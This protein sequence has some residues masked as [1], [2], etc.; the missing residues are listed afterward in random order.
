METQNSLFVLTKGAPGVLL[1]RCSR[2]LVGED[3][4]LLTASRRSEIL[5]SNEG[6]AGKA[7]RTLGVAFRQLPKAA[8]GFEV[9]DESVE[10]DLVFLGLIGMIDP[11]RDE[12]R[13]AVARAKAAAPS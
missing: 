13:D 12:A 4:N 6:L 10:R 11:A 5:Q 3:A 1:E 8:P 2:E 7:L 9:F